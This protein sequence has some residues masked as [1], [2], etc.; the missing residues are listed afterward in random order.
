MKPAPCLSPTVVIQVP[1]LV[2]L[3]MIQNIATPEP[4]PLNKR[5]QYKKRDA[6]THEKDLQNQA[7][8]YAADWSNKSKADIKK[9]K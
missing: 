5:K 2:R 6:K 8:I 3:F 1:N 4:K 7:R 9:E